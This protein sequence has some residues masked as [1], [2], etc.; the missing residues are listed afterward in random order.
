MRV[1]PAVLFLTVLCQG[2]NSNSEEQETRSSYILC[3]KGSATRT[4]RVK[5]ESSRCITTYTKSGLDEEV[6]RSTAPDRCFQV[7]DNIRTNLEKGSWKCRDI[8]SA[9]V[10]QSE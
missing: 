8:S 10:S 9:R 6:G 1:L 2:V 3:K 5:V 4:V 7:L